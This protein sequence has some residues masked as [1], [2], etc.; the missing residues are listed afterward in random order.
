MSTVSLEATVSLLTQWETYY[1]LIGAAAATLTGLVFVVITL[2]A[3]RRQPATGDAIATFSTPTIVHFC[4]AL[5]IAAILSAP[6]GTLWHAALLVG[7]AGLGGLGYVVAVIRRIRRVDTY[8][9]VLEDWLWYVGFPFVAYIAL[10]VAAALLPGNPGAMLFV[11]GAAAILLL[12]VGIHN[13][14]DSVTYLV[15]TSVEEQNED[16]G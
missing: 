6:W 4:T 5:A 2:A 15:V 10:V 1:V 11:I 14:W 3:Q 7:L 16:R 8:R 9:P 13:A 12:F